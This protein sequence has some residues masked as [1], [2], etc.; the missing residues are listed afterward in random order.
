MSTNSPDF[1]APQGEPQPPTQGQPGYPQGQP[2]YQQPPQGTYP[3]GQPGYPQGQPGY[4]Q[5]FGQPP[6]SDKNRTA[7][8]LLCIFLGGLG[9][10]RFYAGK[11]GTGIV[12][13]L[14]AG[15]L[16][17]GWIVDIIMIATGSFRDINNRPILNWE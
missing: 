2:S 13:L 14:T 12:W 3:Q 7:A 10:H 16:G 15:C 9:V 8:L 6:V 11:V 1:P 4:Q 17:I 5:A